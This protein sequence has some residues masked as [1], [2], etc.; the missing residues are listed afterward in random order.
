MSDKADERVLVVPT[1]VFH[2][3][4]LFQGFCP[5]VE[6]YLTRLLEPGHLSYRPRSQV[7]TDPSFKQLIPYVVLHCRDE[8]FHYLRGQKATESRLRALRSLGVGGHIASTDVGLF[9]SPYR[10][11]MLREVAEEVYLESPYRERCVGLIN[12]DSNAVGQVH[13]GIVHIFDLEE[14]KARRRERVLTRAGFAPVLELRRQREEF[15]TWSQ[16]LLD[17]DVLQ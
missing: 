5:E 12:D 17:G 9:E 15:E 16:F 11:G 14:P 3:L 4:G 2:E 6:R 7:E 10:E 8:V 13:L 1:A